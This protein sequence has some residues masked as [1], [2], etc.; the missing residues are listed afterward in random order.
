MHLDG[1]WGRGNRVWRAGL[2]LSNLTGRSLNL[3]H[4]NLFIIPLDNKREWYR[5]HH[6]FIDFLR[7]RLRDWPAD[8]IADL[9]RRAAAWYAQHG[10][11]EEAIHHHLAAKD[12]AQAAD[13][14]ESVGIR[15]IVQGQ[16]APDA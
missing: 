16:T 10:Y 8:E 3:D 5:Y 2:P 15:L 9:H 6:L 11:I 14:I 1:G 7:M 12:F 13:L 4:Y